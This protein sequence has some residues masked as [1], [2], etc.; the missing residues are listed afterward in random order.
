MRVRRPATWRC[1]TP[2]NA[3]H[4]QQRIYCTGRRAWPARPSAITVIIRRPQ[5]LHPTRHT[6]IHSITICMDRRHR[7]WTRT[8]WRISTRSTIPAKSKSRTLYRRFVLGRRLNSFVLNSFEHDSIARSRNDSLEESSGGFPDY[9]AECVKKEAITPP[10]SIKNNNNI[11]INN[12]NETDG[13]PS[14]LQLKTEPI[15]NPDSPESSSI[16]HPPTTTSADDCAGCGRLIQVMNDRRF[17][18]ICTFGTP[19]WLVWLL[20]YHRP[21]SF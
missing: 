5:R 18:H 1:W 16:D 7:R 4:R 8:W 3:T 15:G 17:I 19:L 13:S 10:N 6:S 11:I 2:P 14:L 9:F 20:R 12:N 21:F